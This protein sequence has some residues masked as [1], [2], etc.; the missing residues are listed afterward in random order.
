MTHFTSDLDAAAGEIS[1]M[2]FPARSTFTGMALG[3]AKK[4]LTLGRQGVQKIV[5][6]VTDGMPTLPFN[7]GVAAE[8]LQKVARLIWV[9]VTDAAPKEQLETWERLPTTLHGLLPP[10]FHASTAFSHRRSTA[11]SHLARRSLTLHALLSGGRASRL[12]T[13]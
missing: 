9:P 4:A 1:K 6:V 5:V 3:E 11:S 10:P 7:T 2:Q 13:T 12:R 8:D